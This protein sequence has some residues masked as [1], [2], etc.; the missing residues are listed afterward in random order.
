MYREQIGD[1]LNTANKN[2]SVREHPTKGIYVDGLTAAA[3]SCWEEVL[4][5]LEEGDRTR[6]VASTNMN[7]VS[8]RSHSVFQIT[9]NQTNSE[10]RPL[11]APPHVRNPEGDDYFRAI[12]LYQERQT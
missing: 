6:A 12:G 9:V 7:A 10:V 3:V 8:S 5:V 11:L 2:M 1:L 4:E